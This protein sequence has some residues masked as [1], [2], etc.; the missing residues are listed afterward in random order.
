MAL[1]P[2][3]F[4]KMTLVGLNLA[5]LLCR[6]LNIKSKIFVPLSAGLRIWCAPQYIVNVGR[7]CITV[8]SVSTLTLVI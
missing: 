5:L 8:S 2:G 7:N 3:I 1:M 6:L 4:L